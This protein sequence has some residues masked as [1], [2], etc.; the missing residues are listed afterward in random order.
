MTS[1]MNYVK[2]VVIETALTMSPALTPFTFLYGTLAD[3]AGIVNLPNLS[4]DVVGLATNSFANV[5][6]GIWQWLLYN[7]IAPLLLILFIV[8]FLVGQYFLIKAY[9]FLIKNV[10]LRVISMYNMLID[11][12]RIKSFVNKFEQAVT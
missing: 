3:G 5:M 2:D 8:L 12:P 11:S 4:L 9:Y 1:P 10:V 6:T 7:L